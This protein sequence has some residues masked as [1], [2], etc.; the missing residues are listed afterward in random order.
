MKVFLIILMILAVLFAIYEGVL[1]VIDIRKKVRAKRL[2]K[3]VDNK[4]ENSAVK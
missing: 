2:K 1:F 4:N 3:Q